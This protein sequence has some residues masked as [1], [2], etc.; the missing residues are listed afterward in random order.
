MH[1]LSIAIRK[2]R[3]IC[4]FLLIL[5][6]IHVSTQFSGPTHLL[7]DELAPTPNPLGKQCDEKIIRAPGFDECVTGS[8]SS[9]VG[10]VFQENILE[11]R[12]N[13]ALNLLLKNRK[14][15]DCC[16]F[17]R[18][19]KCFKKFSSN[20]CTE[21]EAQALDLFIQNFVKFLETNRCEGKPFNGSDLCPQSK[22]T[23]VMKDQPGEILI[24]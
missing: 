22:P 10:G 2:M 24:H 3:K 15:T 20:F 6:L 1:S 12:E 9:F 8:D 11:I 21:A 17:W 5:Q 19:F 14:E 13:I 7:I 23:I 18:F 4:N 16:D